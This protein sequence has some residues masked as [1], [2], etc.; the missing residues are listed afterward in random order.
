MKFKLYFLCALLFLT[1]KSIQGQQPPSDPIGDSFFAPELVMQHQEEIKLTDDQK[2]FLKIELR[3]VQMRFTELQW[4]LQDE[5]EKM[6][7]L[8]KQQHIDE[9]QTLAQLDKILDAE[10]EI[11]RLQI[12]L[13]VKIKNSLTAEQQARLQEIKNKA[14]EK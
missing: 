7:A 8:V 3:K 14:R 10:R 13:I 6:V 11:K 2:N 5:S 12:A 9:Q 1:S 4:K